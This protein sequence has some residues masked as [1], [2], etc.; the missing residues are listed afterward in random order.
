LMLLPPSAAFAPCLSPFHA[1][2][3]V[4]RFSPF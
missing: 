4:R 1:I 2:R 3:S